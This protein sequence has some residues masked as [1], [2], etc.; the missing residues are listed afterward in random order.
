SRCKTPSNARYTTPAP[1][2][3][4]CPRTSNRPLANTGAAWR[5]S[6]ALTISS[7]REARAMAG[8]GPS[9]EIDHLAVDP[10]LALGVDL[11]LVLARQLQCLG[12]PDLDPLGLDLDRFAGLDL[13]PH[14]V[15][16]EHRPVL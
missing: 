12:G 14:A 7:T 16:L 5:T 10:D 1:P 6:I 11:D 4:S 2:A 15:H 9:I 3:P 8:G 13:E